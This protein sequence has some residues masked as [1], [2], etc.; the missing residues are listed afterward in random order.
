MSSMRISPQRRRF[1]QL[2]ERGGG[3]DVLCK[4]HHRIPNAKA[5]IAWCGGD[6]KSVSDTKQLSDSMPGN[7]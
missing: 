5:R 1:V 7:G 3:V 2:R 6:V 4:L